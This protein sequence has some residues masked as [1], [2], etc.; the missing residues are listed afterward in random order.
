MALTINFPGSLNTAKLDDIIRR[1]DKMA[2]DQATFDA[3]LTDFLADLEAG[4]QAI[5]DKL[6][7][8]GTPVD[9]TAELGQISDAKAKLDAAVAADTAA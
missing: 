8:L 4:L 1:L 2:T 3:A 6:N 5:A 7:S 9:L